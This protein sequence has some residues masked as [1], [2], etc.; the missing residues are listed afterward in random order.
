VFIVTNT[1]R[2]DVPIY[3]H[4]YVVH[5]SNEWRCSTS[6]VIR[7][8]VNLPASGAI[9]RRLLYV[10]DEISCS[11]NVSKRNTE[12]VGICEELGYM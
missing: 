6:D 12:G 3:L 5:V 11:E 9:S 10:G 2:F 7:Y 8:L 1:Y 4:A